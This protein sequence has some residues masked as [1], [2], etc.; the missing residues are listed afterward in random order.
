MLRR[1]IPILA[2]AAL[3]AIAG[4]RA[5]AQ[6]SVAPQT[7]T[8]QTAAPQTAAPQTAAPPTAA[9]QTAAPQTAAPPAAAPQPAAPQATPPVPEERPPAADLEAFKTEL[10]DISKGF[11]DA[12]TEEELLAL[13]QRL[14]PLRDQ[15]RQR[16]AMLEPR[17]KQ[18]TDRLAE[19]GAAPLFGAAP[20]DATVAGERG[21][22]TAEQGEFDSAVKQARLLAGR[23]DELADRIN[24]RRRQ[25]FT[26]RLFA[27]SA[28]L[29]DP[30]F[31]TGAAAAVP[32]EFRTVRSILRSWM[33]V[34]QATY[35]PTSVLAAVA[36]LIA[37]GAVAGVAILLDAPVHR[38]SRPAPLRQSAACAR[39]PRGPCL[40]RSR[41]DHRFRPGAARLP[42]HS[43]AGRRS[44]ARACGGVGGGGLRPRGGG[45]PVRPWSK[46]PPHHPVGRSGGGPLCGASELGRRRARRDDLSQR[47]APCL[48]GAAR[49]G[50]RH[51]DAV[52]AG[53]RH[54]H[55]ASPVALRPD[56]FQ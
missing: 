28:N 8:P 37:I 19:L 18:I 31:W 27:H 4:A 3:L 35:D 46:L 23:G 56:R 5:V 55:D 25:I 20:E 42:A 16:A 32:A 14:A 21:R 2:C 36:T 44:P 9:P 47:A 39:N 33:V 1:F 22:L 34:A 49:A 45:R 30:G 13:R 17:L 29:F 54:H 52:C 6:Q 10:D 41:P 48:G 43:P 15:V 26:D 51:L 40:G 53:F 7:A 38:A 24:A 11:E 12:N 50:R